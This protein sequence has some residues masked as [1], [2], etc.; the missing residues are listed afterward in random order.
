MVFSAKGSHIVGGEMFYDYIGGNQYKITIKLYRDC[1]SNG[2]A[3]DANL[4]VTVFNGSGTQLS[5]F[6]IP[7]PGSNQLPV[8]FSN[9]C[10]TIPNDICVEEAIYEKTVTLPASSNGWTLTYQRCCRGPSVVNLLDP[11]NQG[12]TSLRSLQFQLTVAQDL[13]IFLHLFCVQM[14]H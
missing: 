13:I 3:Y 9:P 14:T 7:F 4:P 2:A 12:L 8:E 10:V 11:G 5:V 1:N 6:T